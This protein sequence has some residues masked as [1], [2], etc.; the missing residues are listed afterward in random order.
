MEAL[1]TALGLVLALEGLL[2]G[3][4]PDM[5]KRLAAEVAGLPEGTLRTGGLVAMAVGVG[6]VWLVRG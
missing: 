3:G 1:F 4:F 5:A 6:L 2:Y